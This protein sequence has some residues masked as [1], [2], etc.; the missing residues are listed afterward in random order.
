MPEV[1][2]DENCLHKGKEP[3]A[4]LDNEGVLK[5]DTDNRNC[6]N[7]HDNTD[8]SGHTCDHSDS[9]IKQ[10]NQVRAGLMNI[11]TMIVILIITTTT[12]TTTTTLINIATIFSHNN[13]QR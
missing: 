4:P 5:Q 9:E 6:H 7:D 8:S 1:L 11:R 13:A 2:I 3:A 12:T 10:E